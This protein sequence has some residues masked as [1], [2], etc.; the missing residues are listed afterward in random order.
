MVGLIVASFV[1]VSLPL[2]A[3]IVFAYLN[4]NQLSGDAEKVV[5][6]GMELS[7]LSTALGQDVDQLQR[8]FRQAEIV[9]DVADE[10]IQSVYAE[11]QQQLESTINSL[12]SR[13]VSDRERLAHLASLRAQSR[14][15]SE[16]L[17]AGGPNAQMSAQLQSLR[18]AAD[19][20]TE[21][22]GALIS[23]DADQWHEEAERTRSWLARML[24]ISVP[25]ALVLVLIA[26]FL[27]TRPL[28]Q[29]GRA[30]QSLGTGGF[31]HPIKVRGPG[32]LEMLGTE[33]DGLRVRLRQTEA[34]KQHFLRHMSHELK[35]PLAS[36]LEGTEL[37]VDGSLGALENPQSEVAG[38]LRS[39]AQELRHLIENLLDYSAWQAN[40]S[41]LDT[42]EFELQIL[43]S[44]VIDQYRLAMRAKNLSV[45]PRIIP[46]RVRADRSKL[47]T[48]LS[49]LVSNAV[50]YS[51][52]GGTLHVRALGLGRNLIVD[53]A[54]AG[55]NVPIEERRH[56]FEPFFTGTPPA[57]AHVRGSGIGLSLVQEYVIA[58][59]GSIELVDGSY[60]GAHFRVSMPVY[61]AGNKGKLDGKVQRGQGAARAFVKGNQESILSA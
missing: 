54:D 9:G 33:L 23:S 25:M 47:R 12:Q 36:L 1:L 22:T 6:R 20:W 14:K 46:M 37:F 30:I 24:V 35:T 17:I 41:S 4:V 45:D 8:H 29:L 28:G 15:V 40:G 51:P 32:D 27:I 61:L 50:K 60:S 48:V 59:G 2:L 21:T 26:L 56:I 49:N 57:Q 31:E 38:I 10:E 34:E 18:E 39:N 42:S 43:C 3:A 53:V 16:P 11:R 52:V 13:L 5:R 44:Q 7:Q 58:H 19:H 55:P